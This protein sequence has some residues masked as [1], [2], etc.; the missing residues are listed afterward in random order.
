[1]ARCRAGRRGQRLRRRRPWS[2]CRNS[3]SPR[4]ALLKR[5][6]IVC[7]S[8][9]SRIQNALRAHCGLPTCSKATSGG[10]RQVEGGGGAVGAVAGDLGGAAIGVVTLARV[11]R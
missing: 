5:T 1:S 8:T 4:P 9:A 7:P 10:K 2:R 6:S 3:G 11:T